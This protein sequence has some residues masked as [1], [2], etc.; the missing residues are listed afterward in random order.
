MFAPKFHLVFLSVLFGSAACTEFV[1]PHAGP[2]KV[3]SLPVETGEGDKFGPICNPPH[4]TPCPPSPYQIGL[5]LFPSYQQLDVF[6]PL[7]ALNLLAT[8]LPLNLSIISH[9]LSPISNHP[10]SPDWLLPVP[11]LRFEQRLLPTHTFATAPSDL[12]VLIVP[13]G[14]G[15][16]NEDAMPAVV[17]FVRDYAPRLK[18]ILSVCTG[19]AIL[20]RAGVLDG[21][22]ATGN[23]S[24]WQM[25]TP[26]SDKTHW[27]KKARWVEDGNVWT[28]AGVTAG[29][30]MVLAWIDRVYGVRPVGDVFAP[31]SGAEPYGDFV[32]RRMEY[33]RV[34]DSGEDE[35]A[36]QYPGEDVLPVGGKKT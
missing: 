24:A 9:S 2:E 10:Y 3:F 6:G 7:D 29:Q 1:T 26:L 17:E 12:E 30:D 5:L 16:W 8:A 4:L 15:T 33:S 19:S 13:G 31:G 35:F 14:I 32:A 28:A 20:A 18:Y 25:V 22:K 23:K 11:N 36:E 27:I 21:K 34:R